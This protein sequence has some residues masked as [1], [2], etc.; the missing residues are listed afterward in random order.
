[1]AR[2]NELGKW[3]ENVAKEFLVRKGYAIVESNWRMHNYEID[4]IAMKDNR[5]IFV[6]VKTRA[7]SGDDPFDAVDKRKMQH[8]VSSA[9]VYMEERSIAINLEPQFDIIGIVGN[10]DNYE[11]EHIDDAFLP[12]LKTY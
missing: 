7:N 1:M 5:I 11:L 4:I 10:H 9:N 12:Q 6:E 3:G 8:L 2:H